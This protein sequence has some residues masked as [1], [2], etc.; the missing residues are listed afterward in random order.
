MYRFIV[1]IIYLMLPTTLFAT[2]EFQ[3][4]PDNDRA[5]YRFDLA[6]NFYATETE[7]EKDLNEA[8]QLAEEI[9]KYKGK[10]TSSGAVLYE[11]AQK[12]ER[13]NLLTQKLYVYR[14][15]Q[16]S[17]NTKLEAQ[18]TA[19]DRAT[20][21][22]GA[23]AAFVNTE[24]RRISEQDLDQRIAQEPKLSLYRF[25][26]QQNTR[27]KPHTLN[28]EQ[29]ELLAA[30]YPDL[31]GWPAQMFQK[32]IDRTKFSEVKASE[33]SNLNIYRDRQVLSKD[34]NRTVR[35]D[36][37]LK[38]YAEYSS[39]ADL[40]GFAF[41]KQARTANNIASLRH[42]KDAFESSLFD[43]YLTNEQVESFF[44][45]IEKH[46][47]VMQRYVKLRKARIKAISGIDPVEPWDMEVIPADYKRPRFTIA[48]TTEIITNAL[49]FHGKDYTDDLARLMDPG[50]GRL[51]IVK[52]ENRRPGAFAWGIYGS[53]L[54]FYSFAFHGFVDDVQTMAHEAGH[55]VH[56]DLIAQNKVPF[57]YADGPS[58]FTESF[59][60]LNEFVTLDYL[61]N[62]ATTKQ[63]KIFYLE[64][65]L[66][67]AL[68]RFFDIVMRSEFEYIAYQKVL[69][70]EITEAEQLHQ[71]WKQEGLKYV[72]EDYQ[73]HD[74][75][76]YNWTFT[77]HYFSS[78]RYY[79][80]YLFANLM[81]ISYYQRHHSDPQ[82]DEK[83]A[84]LMKNGFPDTP[85]NLL[86]KHLNL[87]PFDPA[88]VQDAVKILESKLN[89][90]ET[91]Y[92]NK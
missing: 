52:G 46:A 67:V 50:Q 2:E 59:A 9:Q 77:P 68:R 35:K 63:D 8:K 64:E 56:Y 81:A 61:Y 79:I 30:L 31:F 4:I 87:N 85:V 16:Y 58:Y 6:K 25:Y 22:I 1:L 82:F 13:L 36:A 42:F 24:L 54:V 78:P 44:R 39:S 20:S 10:V 3:S 12:L 83:Y 28:S 37:A 73:K 89:D 15:L 71:L 27:Y 92:T 18:L 84:T 65:W 7:W 5:K 70:N 91:L 48:Q 33:A 55:V 69:K 66:A 74:F 60:M 88:A 26:L 21:E 90:L 38:L 34:P 76:K 49:A 43:A 32:L 17:V 40:F 14:Y 80:N 45:A 19:A 53:P 29:E 47:P 62:Q 23:K 57:V 41:L 11:L 72:G 51:D 75:L 86:Q